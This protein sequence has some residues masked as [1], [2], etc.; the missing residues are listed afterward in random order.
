[1]IKPHLIFTKYKNSFSVN[2]SN[3]EK[4]SVAQ[5]QEVEYFV[6]ARKGIFNFETYCFE[7]QKKIEFPEF[8]SLLKHV[9][10]DSHCEENIIISSFQ[11]RVGIGQ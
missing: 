9:G 11:P 6:S 8:I 1:M 7:I 5:I 2:V 10:L 4:L 3:M